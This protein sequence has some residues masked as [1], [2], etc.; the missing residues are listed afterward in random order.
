M[1]NH[2]TKE[3][4]KVVSVEDYFKMYNVHLEWSY[5]PLVE[6]NNK[7][8]M[9]PIKVCHICDGQKYLYKLEEA[10]ISEMIKFAVSKPAERKDA[11]KAGLRS[12]N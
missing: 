7:G 9:Y 12:L 5:Y 3:M 2:Q 6:V 8:T 11:I 4:V 10:Q 1:Y